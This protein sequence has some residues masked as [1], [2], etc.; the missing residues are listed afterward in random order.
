[1][2]EVVGGLQQRAIAVKTPTNQV[3]QAA[4]R[5][6]MVRIRFLTKRI[7]ESRGSG[8][9]GSRR[10]GQAGD[11]EGISSERRAL[12]HAPGGFA[13]GEHAGHDEIDI[14]ANH[15][16]GCHLWERALMTWQRVTSV[17]FKL[18]GGTEDRP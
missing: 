11:A 13:R 3:R 6:S 8:G 18:A 14:T 1:V 15:S 9:G 12:C 7:I 5:R 17:V 4:V 2:T 16:V 10:A